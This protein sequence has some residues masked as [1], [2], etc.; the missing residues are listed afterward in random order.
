MKLGAVLAAVALIGTACGDD[1]EP[2][3]E[4]GGG[5][6]DCTWVIGNMGAHSGD[7][8]SVGLPILDGVN[9]AIDQANEA[10]D[11]P[12]TLEIQSEDSQGSPD[13]APQLANSLIENEDLVAVAGPYFSGE[14]LAI[15]QVFSDAGVAFSGTGTNETIDEQGFTTWFRAVAPDNIQAE[16]AADYIENSLGAKKVAVVHDNQDYSKGLAEGVLDNLTVEA[17][18]GFIIDPEGADYSAVVQ[19][20]IDFDPDTVFYG[21]YT[22]QA[23]PLLKQMRELGL[24]AQFVT[25][26]GSKDPTFGELAGASNAEG[27]QATC[28]C[29]D[30]L[31]IAG[32][33]EFVSGMQAEF[34]NKA[35]GTFA[36]DM[37]DV[38]NII[39]DAL[40]ELNGDESIEDVRA[41]VVEYFQNAEGLEGVA[42]AYSWDDTGEFEGGPED[43]WVYEWDNNEENFVSLGPA[44]E[45]LGG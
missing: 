17:Q 18:G 27:A 5:P 41:H 8:A 45:L 33:E 29:A 21:G 22:P 44:S 35:P 37:Y 6:A 3:D 16:V 34:G 2:T 42:K 14:T 32:A 40:R 28:P 26:D 11:V 30:P 13:Q 12:C 19:E 36:A 9:Y 15:G 43:I 4:T 20:I 39:I 23:G 31:Q 1:D 7:Y 24:E 38:T 25:D 10:G